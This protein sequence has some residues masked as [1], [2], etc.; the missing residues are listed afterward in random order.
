MYGFRKN[1]TIC[2]DPT[3]QDVENLASLV[4]IF[5]N[6][7]RLVTNVEKGS[8]L[9]IQRNDLDMSGIMV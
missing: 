7:T 4:H 9:P 5:S 2:L 1:T 8:I 3:T 6:A